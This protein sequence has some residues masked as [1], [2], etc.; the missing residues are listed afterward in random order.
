MKKHLSSFR[1]TTVIFMEVFGKG[2]MA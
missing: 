1:E 2:G